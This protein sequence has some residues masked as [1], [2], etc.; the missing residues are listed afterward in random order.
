MTTWTLTTTTLIGIESVISKSE[1][2]VSSHECVI[3]VLLVSASSL[4]DCW[5][6]L[7][8]GTLDWERIWEWKMKDMD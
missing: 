8:V 3:V 2:V 7:E 6:A 1:L 4:V 5:V